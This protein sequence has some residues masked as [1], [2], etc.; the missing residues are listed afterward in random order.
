MSQCSLLLVNEVRELLSEH[1]T[2]VVSSNVLFLSSSDDLTARPPLPKGYFH[3]KEQ[4][5]SFGT[6]VPDGPPGDTPTEFHFP[7]LLFQIRVQ[8]TTLPVTLVATTHSFLSV[9]LFCVELGSL[10]MTFSGQAL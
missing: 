3:V 8:T 9:G 2:K 6:S 7:T 1:R 4:D 10:L 5:Q